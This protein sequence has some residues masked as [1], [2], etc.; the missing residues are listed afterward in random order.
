M[1]TQKA[2]Q[3]QVEEVAA[4]P[5]RF[6]VFLLAK[7]QAAIDDLV[8]L[9]GR[10]T[11]R[12]TQS[13]NEKVEAVKA[14]FG[15]TDSAPVATTKPAAKTSSLQA[16]ATPP[17]V[18]AAAVAR[19]QP[20][21]QPVVRPVVKVVPPAPKA[22]PAASTSTPASVAPKAPAVDVIKS[23]ASTAPTKTEAASAFSFGGLFSSSSPA[24]PAAKV[25]TKPVVKVETK[26]ITKVEVKPITKVEVKPVTKVEVKPVTKVEVKPVTT[27]LAAPVK[28]VTPA[29]A[30]A[31][32]PKPAPVAA[33]ASVNTKL[34][35][36]QAKQ[37][38]TLLKAQPGALVQLDDLLQAYLEGKASGDAILRQLIYTTGSRD[39]AL[40]VFPDIIGS[41]PAG[42][43]RSSLN[44]F[45]QQK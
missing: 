37:A 8:A 18:P 35:N 23:N 17:T 34:L 20:V 44:A 40:S 42:D 38:L 16:T 14:K 10:L 33:P 15:I 25:E 2:I 30:P 41:L 11:Q 12:L 22:A 43:K 45:Y 5:G 19:A 4:A 9:P 26:P 31:P 39:A 28:V 32:L 36:A 7:V 1:A 3:K 6:Q 29:A 21:A 13:V 24:K 27:R